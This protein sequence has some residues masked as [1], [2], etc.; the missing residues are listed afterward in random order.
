MDDFRGQR[1]LTRKELYKESEQVSAL[2]A[3][4]KT[5]ARELLHHVEPIWPAEALTAKIHGSVTMSFDIDLNGKVNNIVVTEASPKG[6][7]EESAITALAQWRYAPLAKPL[8]NILT[9]F[10][11][12]P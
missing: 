8:S 9:R 7:F 12:T 2:K 6:T 1:T 3:K 11:F 10:D 5:R 4:I